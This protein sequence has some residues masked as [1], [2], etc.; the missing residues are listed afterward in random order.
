MA[1]QLMHMTDLGSMGRP[2]ARQNAVELP[3]TGRDM[4]CH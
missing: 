2:Q 4:V 1:P 3:E